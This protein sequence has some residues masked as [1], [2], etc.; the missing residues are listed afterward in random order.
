MRIDVDLFSGRPNPGWELS[1]EQARIVRELVARL[2]P[3]PTPRE[4]YDG[5]GYR[6][7][8]LTEDGRSI[9][10]FREDVLLEE[11][12]KRESRHDSRRELE[13]LLLEFSSEHLEPELYQFLASQVCG[14][15]G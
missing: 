12:G 3:S 15:T 1:P 8:V 11:G 14:N 6:G 2:T 13:G 9:S 7:F 10:V 5:L 4:A